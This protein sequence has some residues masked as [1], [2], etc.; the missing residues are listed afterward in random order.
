MLYT[1]SMGG[2]GPLVGLGPVS[3]MQICFRINKD[4]P[5]QYTYFHVFSGIAI[6]FYN[7]KSSIFYTHVACEAIV[8]NLLALCKAALQ[9]HLKNF[10]IHQVPR[11]GGNQCDE[12]Q[13]VIRIY[14]GKFSWETSELRSFKATRSH[15]ITHISHRTSLYAQS[16][17]I[18]EDDSWCSAHCTWLFMSRGAIL[19]S[20]LYHIHST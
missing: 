9:L 10:R 16:W 19:C 5:I 17:V 15:H 14:Q 8:V 4:I 1:Q 2:L 7:D 18:F 12:Q 20:T 11:A 3:Y 13:N 6:Y